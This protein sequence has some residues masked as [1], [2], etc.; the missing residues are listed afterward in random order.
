MR[1]LGTVGKPAFQA[2]IKG[3]AGNKSIHIPDRGAITRALEEWYANY[4]TELK[5]LLLSQ[6]HL[7]T[8]SDIWSV[9][10]K[11]FIVMTVHFINDDLLRVSKVL[12][13]RRI[14]G[15]HDYLNI[16]KSIDTIHKNFE[17]DVKKIE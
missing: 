13:C 14:N 9:L 7:C 8:T 2:M 17:L 15:T 10:N 5:K 3:F 11:S 12:A 4:C 1:P 6:R 16:S